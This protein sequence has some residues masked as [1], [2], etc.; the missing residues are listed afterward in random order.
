MKLKL[1]DVASLKLCDV[2]SLLPPGPQPGDALA[3]LRLASPIFAIHRQEHSQWI[4]R[5]N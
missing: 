3:V 2:A 4:K 1:I 5:P